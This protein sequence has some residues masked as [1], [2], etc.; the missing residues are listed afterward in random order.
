MASPAGVRT[1]G[2]KTDQRP[3]VVKTTRR[4]EVR[5]VADCAGCSPRA[6]VS[7]WAC[8]CPALYESSENAGLEPLRLKLS[9]TVELNIH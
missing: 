5:A 6:T 7:V 4:R 3:A 1:P 8:C 2:S 9:P